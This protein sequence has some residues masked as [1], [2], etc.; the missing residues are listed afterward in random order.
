MHSS[1]TAQISAIGCIA[2]HGLCTA[3]AVAQSSRYRDVY[4]LS[5]RATECR[6]LCLVGS[7]VTGPCAQQYWLNIIIVTVC[8]LLSKH[9]P[10]YGCVN[11]ASVTP[12][13]YMLLIHQSTSSISDTTRHYAQSV[14]TSVM[15]PRMVKISSSPIHLLRMDS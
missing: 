6:L 13:T 9:I 5:F 12:C 10:T 14:C 1:F 2:F 8:R 15:Y 3:I 7:L 4:P 11:I